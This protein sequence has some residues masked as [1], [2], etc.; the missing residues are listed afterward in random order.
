MTSPNRL[1]AEIA[2]GAQEIS[3]WITG[4]HAMLM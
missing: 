4:K 2:E 3:M 1:T